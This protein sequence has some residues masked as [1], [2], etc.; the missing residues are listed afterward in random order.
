MPQAVLIRIL[1]LYDVDLIEHDK[2]L[3]VFTIFTG[4]ISTR[5]GMSFSRNLINTLSFHFFTTVISSLNK[6]FKAVPAYQVS[7]I[8]GV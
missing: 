5:Y 6:M 2:T 1:M 4:H 7:S 8:V 3:R